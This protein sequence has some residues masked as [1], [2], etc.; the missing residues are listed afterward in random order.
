MATCEAAHRLLILMLLH[1][2][3]L[4][5][6]SP[7]H[8]LRR[9]SMPLCL[10]CTED[11]LNSHEVDRRLAEYGPNKLPASTRNPYLVFLG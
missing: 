2:L 6:R 5:G 3:K 10:Q 8:T 1:S 11:G 9:V 4:P 7:W